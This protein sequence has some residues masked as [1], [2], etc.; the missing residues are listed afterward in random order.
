M[1][2]AVLLLVL[3]YLLTSC[4]VRPNPELGLIYGKVMVSNS[5]IFPNDVVSEYYK[6]IDVSINNTDFST[7][8]DRDGIFYIFNIP[9]G[10]YDIISKCSDQS[11]YIKKNV[12]IKADSISL[13]YGL[14]HELHGNKKFIAE[15]DWLDR[16]LPFQN[17]KKRGTIRCNLITNVDIRDLWDIHLC[18]RDLDYCFTLPFNETTFS[19]PDL[20]PGV[21][22]FDVMTIGYKEIKIRNAIV[23]ADSISVYNL[24]F[25]PDYQE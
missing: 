3:N 6:S 18:F 25:I 15:H 11:V 5:Q 23:K 7:T 10:T 22:S 4:Y 12:N 8:I 13:I 20:L 19:I 16:K 14:Y 24:I 9:P 21:Y 1:K 2:K 17:L